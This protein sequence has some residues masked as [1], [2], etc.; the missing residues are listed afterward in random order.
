MGLL[1]G[2][3]INRAFVV[4]DTFALPVQGTETR[5]NAAQEADGYMIA[6]RDGSQLVSPAASPVAQLRRVRSLTSEPLAISRSTDRSTSLD[7]SVACSLLYL[8]H[9]RPL[10]TSTDSRFRRVQSGYHCS[11]SHLSLHFVDRAG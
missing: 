9:K 1:Q 11:S 7:V 8:K 2:K 6:H 5:V 10:L 4:M 3:I